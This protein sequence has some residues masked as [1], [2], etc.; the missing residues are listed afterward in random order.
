MLYTVRV[1][2]IGAED[3]EDSF[4][5]EHPKDDAARVAL[6]D[7]ANSAYIKAIGEYDAT[8]TVTLLRDGVSLDNRLGT[9]SGQLKLEK[10]EPVV[11]T[12]STSPKQGG[13]SK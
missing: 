10:G 11:A 4:E 2:R 9:G 6:S 5:D 7:K 1:R 8:H 12:G 3:K 13:F